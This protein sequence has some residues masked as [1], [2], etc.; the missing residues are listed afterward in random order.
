[1]RE[2]ELFKEYLAKLR[3]E[4]LQASHQ[5][6]LGART[7]EEM[8]AACAVA[9]EADIVTRIAAALKALENDTG[10]FVVKFLQN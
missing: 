7:T 6:M 8:A 9:H 1:M 10:D 5:K 2:I 3:A 4:R